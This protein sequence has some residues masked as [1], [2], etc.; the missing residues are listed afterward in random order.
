MKRWITALLRRLGYVPASE[1]ATLEALL[2]AEKQRREEADARFGVTYKMSQNLDDRIEAL[3]QELDAANKQAARY[4]AMADELLTMRANSLK[5]GLP[6][7]GMFSAELIQEYRPDVDRDVYSVT[8]R[9]KRHTL[10]FAVDRYVLTDMLEVPELLARR[11]RN[12]VVPA[13]ERDLARAFAKVV[14]YA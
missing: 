10:S 6:M 14:Q 11:V 2:S 8:I 3:S 1:V 4:Q 7:A 5:Y 12:E 13:F 9:P